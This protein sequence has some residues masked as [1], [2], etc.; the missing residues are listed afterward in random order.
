MRNPTVI[1]LTRAFKPSNAFLWRLLSL[2]RSKRRR[3]RRQVTQPQPSEINGHDVSDAP[4]QRQPQK[5]NHGINN[6]TTRTMYSKTRPSV[7]VSRSIPYEIQRINV[8]SI[9]S[10]ARASFTLNYSLFTPAIDRRKPINQTIHQTS[11]SLPRPRFASSSI[12]RTRCI[13]PYRSSRN[14]RMTSRCTCSHS[15][16]RSLRRQR[17]RLYDDNHG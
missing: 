2:S 13:Y 15:C 3:R 1:K 10:R 7:S 6:Q 12:A 17:R 11:L 9:R 16:S 14:A 4:K 5:R 8:H